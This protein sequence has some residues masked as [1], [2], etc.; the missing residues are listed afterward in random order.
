MG[1]LSMKKVYTIIALVAMMFGALGTIFGNVIYA[2]R[3]AQKVDNIE[4]TFKEHKTDENVHIPLQ[5][6][7]DLFLSDKVFNHYEK[8]H[9]ELH[10]QYLRELD[11]I[12]DM[13]RALQ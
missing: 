6:S 13:I 9:I 8:N 4:E 3:Y 11:I 7:L 10:N 1:D 12:K 2:G 5:K